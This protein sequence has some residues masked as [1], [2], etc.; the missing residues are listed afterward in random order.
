MA[1]SVSVLLLL[2]ILAVIF[3]K[4]GGL[5]VWHAVVCILLGFFLAGT[6]MASTIG[7]GVSATADMV[8]SIR[9]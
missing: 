6:S 5:K 8:S 9:P 7:S 3:I 4:N 1:V 2:A